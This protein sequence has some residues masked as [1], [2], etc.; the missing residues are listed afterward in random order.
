MPNEDN[1]GDACDSDRDNDGLP[2]L[3]EVVGCGFGPTDS[4]VP[5]LDDTY[6]DNGNG[7][8]A[9]PMGTDLSDDGPSW[10]TDAD[11]APDGLECALGSNPNNRSSLPGVL[12]NDGGDDDGDTLLNG[13]EQR[14]GTNP[15]VVDSD[16][17][18][19]SDC[20]EVADE[21]GDGFANFPGDVLEVARAAASLSAVRS[22]VMDAN[23]DG[24]LNFPGDVI[25]FAKVAGAPGY[26]PNPPA[27]IPDDLDRDGI[28]DAADNCARIYNATQANTQLPPFDNGP[29]LP[30][31]DP[32]VPNQD[33]QG[34]VCDPDADNDGAADV[35]EALGCG[36]GPT[37]AGVPLVDATYDDNH[38]AL[39]APPMGTDAFDD[40]PSAD[41]DGDGAIDGYECANGSNPKDYNSKPPALPD[42]NQ[43][44]DGDGLLNGWERRGWGTSLAVGDSDGDGIGDCRE[45]VDVNGDGFLNFPGDT[46]AS[47]R[48][49]AI[50]SFGRNGTYD[51]NKDGFINF[52]GDVLESAR[53]V[54][55]SVPC[56]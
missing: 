24:V 7:N 32:T 15:Q 48:A 29:T 38:N 42:D 5:A 40:G 3:V 47:A 51:L 8:P 6:D 14:L 45:A 20:R 56:P 36:L 50:L 17:D 25:F 55:G 49:A 13:W 21:N 39:A 16:G 44:S 46:F 12:P 22:G 33:G 43:D 35:A 2:D 34:D 30:G 23:K 54:A 10:D 41:T 9:P 11:G 18:G 1:L 26:C 37:D 31:D 52:P 19:I 27:P 28:T 53:R 4:G